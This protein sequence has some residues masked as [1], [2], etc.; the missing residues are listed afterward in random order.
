MAAVRGELAG[1]VAHLV[2]GRGDLDVDDRLEHDRPRLGD[3]VEECLAPGGDERD[4]LRI[5]R[6]VLAVVDDDAHV[7][8]REAGDEAASR[9]RRRTPFSTAGMNWL[10]IAPPFTLSTN[11][12]PS[13]RGSGS[14]FRNTSPN[15][16][17]PPVCFL[18]RLWP[19]ALAVIVSR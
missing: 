6:V 12:K 17:A 9:A 15:W 11:S 19:S 4:V 18:W 8:Q 1:D 2:V 16:P 7:L 3:R 10:G 14:T 13:P 5:D